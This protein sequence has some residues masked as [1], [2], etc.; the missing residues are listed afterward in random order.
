[1][2][3][4]MKGSTWPALRLITDVLAFCYGEAPRCGARDEAPWAEVYVSVD[5]ARRQA[6]E[7]GVPLS[8][9]LVLLCVHG[10]LHVGGMDDEDRASWGAMK[11]AEFETVMRIL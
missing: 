4:R 7:R 10:L 1:K 2:R 6:R 3:V 9:E 5:T 11:R 8:H